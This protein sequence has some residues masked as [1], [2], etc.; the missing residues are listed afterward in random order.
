[1]FSTALFSVVY[2][3]YMTRRL[4]DIWPENSALFNSENTSSLKWGE[5]STN[6]GLLKSPIPTA[7]GRSR[8]NKRL[9]EIWYLSFFPTLS[10]DRFY[11]PSLS[12]CNSEKYVTTIITLGFLLS[13]QCLQGIRTGIQR[14]V[15]FRC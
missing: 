7:L 15:R 9:I 10:E 5:R 4:F 12:L 2:T 6:K 1:M 8:S 14:R 3:Q 11:S 13:C